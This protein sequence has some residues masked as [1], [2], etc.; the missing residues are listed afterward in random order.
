MNQLKMKT[1]LSIII[2]T[3][4]ALFNLSHQ[5]FRHRIDAFSFD[6]EYGEFPLAYNMFGSAVGLMTKLKLVP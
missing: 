5:E 1:H 3:L 4:L 6:N 2:L